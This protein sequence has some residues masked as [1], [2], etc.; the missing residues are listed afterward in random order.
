MKY[1]SKLVKLIV[2][3]VFEAFKNNTFFMKH[4]ENLP[5]DLQFELL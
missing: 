2:S 3:Y 5:Q 4:Y 1:D